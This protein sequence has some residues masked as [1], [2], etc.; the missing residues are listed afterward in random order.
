MVTCY[1]R[2]YAP[3]E[4]SWELSKCRVFS[5]SSA[6]VMKVWESVL[7]ALWHI[8]F[9]TS[10]ARLSWPIPPLNSDTLLECLLFYASRLCIAFLKAAKSFFFSS[11][12]DTFRAALIIVECL[13]QNAVW[14]RSCKNHVLAPRSLTH[15]NDNG[16]FIW[17]LLCSCGGVN[18]IG[19]EVF[20]SLHEWALC[21]K[22]EEEENRY[23]LTLI[24]CF[25]W[26]LRWHLLYNSI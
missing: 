15:D 11:F 26:S 7:S 20:R 22:S 25:C 24:V 16:N 3:K 5:R 18:W 23:L 9:E 19:N 6:A 12:H 21:G 14:R 4:P 10:L 1:A 13:L 2:E 17:K 8:R